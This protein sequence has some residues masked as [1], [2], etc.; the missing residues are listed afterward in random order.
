MFE[1]YAEVLRLIDFAGGS[2]A[3][4]KKLQKMV[5][6]AQQRG[7][8][9]TEVFRYH[10]YGPFSE[11]LAIEI[12]EM[13]AFGFVTE[14]K[15]AGQGSAL[16]CSLTQQGRSLLEKYANPALSPMF[17]HLIAEMSQLDSRTLELLATVFFL[18][19]CHVSTDE[20]LDSI[21]SLKPDRD[22]TKAEVDKA[23]S[24]L[25]EEG[26]LEGLPVS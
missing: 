2:I 1:N 5:F 17:K 19:K 12:E 10:L 23:I 11:Q 13:K 4:R 14:E 24:F 26:F 21:K 6:L 7:W 3:G 8:P 18:L 25:R 15:Q 20:M 22:Y 9:F 16:C